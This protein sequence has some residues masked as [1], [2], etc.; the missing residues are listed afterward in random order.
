MGYTTLSPRTNIYFYNDHSGTKYSNETCFLL[1]MKLFERT[2]KIFSTI[3]T[4]GPLPV[5]IA[6]TAKK[7]PRRGN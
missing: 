6:T 3:N 1:P 4:R 2:G 5:P 7:C